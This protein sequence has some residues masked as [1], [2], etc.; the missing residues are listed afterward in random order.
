MLELLGL[1]DNLQFAASAKFLTLR[2]I[3]S[4]VSHRDI[5]LILEHLHQ[6][7]VTLNLTTLLDRSG[8]TILHRAVY[9]GRK[10]LVKALLDT[11]LVDVN[12]KNNHGLTPLHLAFAGHFCDLAEDLVNYGAQEVTVDGVGRSPCDV[13]SYT[14]EKCSCPT[15]DQERIVLQTDS[16]ESTLW[17]RYKDSGWITASKD[18]EYLR[19]VRNC[20]IDVRNSSMSRESFHSGYK[21]VFKPVLIQGLVKSW[22]AWKH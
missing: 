19:S 9:G 8:N 10:E 1:N 13:M 17:N 6:E 14:E 4:L 18:A 16:S 12:S 21:A 5:E 22:P 7:N 3:N 11:R 15:R 20:A 2:E